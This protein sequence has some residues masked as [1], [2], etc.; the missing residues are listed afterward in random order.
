MKTAFDHLVDKAV[1]RLVKENNANTEEAEIYRF[2]VEV[3]FLKALHW[4]SDLLIAVCL[5]KVPE[6]IV[7]FGVFCA[8]RRNTGG[9]HA[10]TRI[11]CYL[12]S[13]LAVVATLAAT[14][15]EMTL[16][17]MCGISVCELITLMLISPIKNEN[18]P[19]DDEEISYFRKRLYILA[20]IY[21]T[22]FFFTVRLGYFRL[23]WLYTIGLTLVTLLAAL[24]KA[25]YELS[26]FR[27]RKRGI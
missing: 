2:G 4:V 26:N 23:V 24:G 9:Y 13:C 11:G 25:G 15:A 16:P 21:V 1:D 3:T 27:Q 20:I 17:Y 19:M 8:F 12:F 6:F 18:R 14:E 7:I 22:A 10:K 5:G